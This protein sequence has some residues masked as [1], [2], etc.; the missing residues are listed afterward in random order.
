MRWPGPS[1][2]AC[3][4][5]GCLSSPPPGLG[6]TD[7]VGELRLGPVEAGGSFA[8]FDPVMLLGQRTTCGL[9][10]ILSLSSVTQLGPEKPS[11]QTHPVLLDAVGAGVEFVLATDA[12]VHKLQ[13]RPE[14]KSWHW[15]SFMPRIADAAVGGRL[16]TISVSGG[17]ASAEE[18]P[19]KL[20]QLSLF[21][22]GCGC[23]FRTS[24]QQIHFVN[25]EADQKEQIQVPGG[26]VHLKLLLQFGAGAAF[27]AG[28]DGG[29]F[30]DFVLTAGGSQ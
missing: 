3:F 19:S 23:P 13:L 17:R 2:S 12:E 14:P 28:R 6:Q 22:H 15:P 29:A 24:V 30:V 25:K 26:Q 4:R 10:T 21:R 9:S 7:V 16:A 27:E 1:W 18:T 5:S 8:G 11:G 20:M